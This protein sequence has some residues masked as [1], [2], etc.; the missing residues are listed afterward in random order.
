MNVLS[1]GY[2]RQPCHQARWLW[3]TLRAADLAVLDPAR[4][5]ADAIAERNLAGSRDIAAVPADP[6]ARDGPRRRLGS[7]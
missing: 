3:R 6:A 2:R 7:P 5:L 1:P 4:V